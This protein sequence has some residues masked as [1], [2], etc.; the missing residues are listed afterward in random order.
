M[1][2]SGTSPSDSTN[3]SIGRT[4]SDGFQYD[5]ESVFPGY[6]P[7]DANWEDPQPLA[8]SPPNP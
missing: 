6:N 2:D 4:T 7:E 8:D 1:S 5:W 3:A